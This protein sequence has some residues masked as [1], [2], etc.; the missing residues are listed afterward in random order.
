MPEL[1]SRETLKKTQVI[2]KKRK[3]NINIINNLKKLYSRVRFLQMFVAILLK[4]FYIKQI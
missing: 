2:I 3:K 1:C 4:T